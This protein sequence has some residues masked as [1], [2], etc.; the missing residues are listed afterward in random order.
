MPFICLVALE[1]ASGSLWGVQAVRLLMFLEAEP[2]DKFPAFRLQV[3]FG[4]EGPELRF[5]CP[6]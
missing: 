3:P 2:T 6:F 1:E 5:V 4:P